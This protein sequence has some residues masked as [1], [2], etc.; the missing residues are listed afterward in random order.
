MNLDLINNLFNNLKENKL[1]Q[2]FTKELSNYLEKNSS[3]NSFINNWVDLSLD[4]LTLFNTKI[5]TKYRDEILIERN[6]I[7]KNYANCINENEDM[8]Y[9]YNVSS[10]KNNC[11][12]L[13]NCKSNEI[14][15]ESLDNL[16]T[17]SELGSVLIKSSD[18]LY[19]DLEATQVVSSQI[20]SMII[21][22]IEE[23]K[24]YLSDHRIDGHVYEVGEKSSG[25]IWLYDLNSI[26]GTSDGIEEVDFPQD[27]YESAKEGDS[28][29][30]MDGSYQYLNS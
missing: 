24:Q 19:L 7:L 12:N 20:N 17:G 5:T 16:P 14:I 10:N 9:I 25:R 13:Y 26:D 8:F 23:Q 18:G 4:D 3:N 11:Y 30:F 2:N 21:E 28:F 6:N 22:K 15:T 27:L 29:V 1:I